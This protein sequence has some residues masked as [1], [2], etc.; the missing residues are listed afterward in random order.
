MTVFA[1]ARLELRR[2]AVR[3][4]AWALAALTIAWLAWTFILGLGQFVGAQVKLAA[5]ADAPGFT[6][7]VAIPL[8]AELAK[9]AF[10]VV[11]LMTMTQ[12]AGERR[13]GTLA[14]L[15]S[16][17]LSPSR[18]VLG[19]YLA[20]LVWLGLWLLATLAMPLVVGI[21]STADWGKLA[22]AT[23]GTA[24]LLATLAAIGIACSAATG[25]AAIA[26]AMALIVT[27]A[28]WTIDRGAQAA[29][30]SGG[31]LEWLTMATHLQNLLR[32]LV[33]TADLMWFALA[34]A[35]S[36]VLAIRRLGADRER[37]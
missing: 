20:V 21:G 32:G 12:L 35:L 30:V 26:A 9:L 34:I 17:G 36:L 13:G 18:I 33:S 19:K 14:L 16:T 15:A 5:V 11:P 1:V 3:P 6:D 2:L 37:Q 23:L 27:L 28:L 10:L 22:A 31:F 7:L 8:L 24:L 29:G 25:F 4:L